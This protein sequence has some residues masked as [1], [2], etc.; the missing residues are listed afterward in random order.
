MKVALSIDCLTSKTHNWRLHCLDRAWHSQRWLSLSGA[1]RQA[2][3]IKEAISACLR[4]RNEGHSGRH[5]WGF[6]PLLGM[7]EDLTPQFTWRPQH[8]ESLP[9]FPSSLPQPTSAHS[10]SAKA[11]LLRKLVPPSLLTGGP[12]CYDG[13]CDSAYDIGCQSLIGI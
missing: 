3:I 4:W 12:K 8:P 1:A 9:T 13:V 11:W 2:I 7:A 6:Y 5:R 10:N